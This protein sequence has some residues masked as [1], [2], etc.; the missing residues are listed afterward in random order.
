MDI[1]NS[2]RMGRTPPSWFAPTGAKR[3]SF[4]PLGV[5]LTGLGNAV[6]PVAAALTPNPARC[7][8]YKTRLDGIRRLD[9][10]DI[11]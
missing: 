2:D 9:S 11:V 4:D 3:R 6:A 1:P 7:A 5:Y 8:A 10:S